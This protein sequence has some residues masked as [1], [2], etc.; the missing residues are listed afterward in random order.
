MKEYI[1]KHPERQRNV[2]SKRTGCPCRLT[3]KVYPKTQEVLGMYKHEH[4]HSIGNKN[5]K[6]TPLSKE[7]RNKIADMLKSG[8]E[9]DRIVR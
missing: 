2:P 4:A 7:V 9:N 6:F 5:L 1:P 8:I 3:V